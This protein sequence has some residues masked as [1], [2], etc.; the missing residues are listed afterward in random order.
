MHCNMPSLCFLYSYLLPHTCF[1]GSSKVRNVNRP[2]RS[3]LIC[4]GALSLDIYGVFD[5]HG[6][7][8][9]ATYASR[10]VTD[11]LLASLKEKLA[12]TGSSLNAASA[13]KQDPQLPPEV[14]RSLRD[15]W[16]LQDQ[17]TESLPES[18]ADTFDRLQEDFFQQTKVSTQKDRSSSGHRVGGIA[19]LSSIQV[20]NCCCCNQH[21]T[22]HHQ[23]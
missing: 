16:G 8:Q 23:H 1:Q 14:D 13:A 10:N 17:I 3:G 18:L 22:I 9:A 21:R 4:A 12:T 15:I 19:D 5:G 7:K 6:G 11:K 2:Q 20:L